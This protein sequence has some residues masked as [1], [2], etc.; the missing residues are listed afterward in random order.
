[1]S[2]ERDSEDIPKEEVLRILK[3]EAGFSA[4][5]RV[6]D[7]FMQ[8]SILVDPNT[9][10]LDAQSKKY[11]EIDFVARIRQE[12][13]ELEGYERRV[14]LLMVGDVKSS[15]TPIVIFSADSS[16]AERRPS[17]VG[18]LCVWS[19]SK[20]DPIKSTV[21]EDVLI[22]RSEMRVGRIMVK[23]TK[24]REAKDA[25]RVNTQF[26]IELFRPVFTAAEFF[27]ER[28]KEEAELGYMFGTGKPRY[29]TVVIPILVA[30]APLF[31]YW[32][33]NGEEHFNEVE[34]L[35][36]RFSF[37]P[38]ESSLIP[39]FQAGAKSLPKMLHC[40]TASLKLAMSGASLCSGMV[41]I[42]S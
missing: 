21:I 32:Y 30:D 37:V 10:Y 13:P 28:E 39:S 3:S 42:K 5:L 19:G 35:P 9:F 41:G 33:R 1:M 24:K 18:R 7:A 14:D 23:V 36:V 31:E 29:L 17:F 11:R 16:P 15:S 20:S 25:N 4:E 8:Q 34:L 26:A 27:S 12:L 38:N 2:V 40:A 6:F 22:P